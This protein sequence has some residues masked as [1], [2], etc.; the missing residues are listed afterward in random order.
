MQTVDWIILAIVIVAALIGLLLGFGKCLKFFTSG[1]FGF[2]I[3]LVVVYFFLG[4]F[5]SWSF[6]RDLMA[7]LNELMVNA[8][9]GFVD[10]LIKIHIEKVILAIGL[11][12]VVQIA[13]I[14][15]VRIIKNVVEIK[16]PA[17]RVI[18]KILGMGLML[19]LVAMLTLIMFQIVAWV[20]G[21][22]A[23]SF[24][25]YIENSVFRLDW[26]YEHNPLIWMFQSI[27]SV[28]F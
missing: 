19:A 17:V 27:A 25:H 9:N 28:A 7:K 15:I 26:V 20:G 2:C 22:S 23:E 4:V 11:F 16:N 10:L 13:R 1:I 8:N 3:S 24:K 6:V 21:E 12:I 14:I 18:N 5:S